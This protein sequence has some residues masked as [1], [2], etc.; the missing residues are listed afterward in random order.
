MSA[1]KLY[2][3]L[4]TYILLTIYTFQI[5]TIGNSAFQKIAPKTILNVDNADDGHYDPYVLLARE[6]CTQDK[7][8]A[9]KKSVYI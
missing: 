6:K 1:I 4:I 9:M 7:V 2:L 5:V 8:Y 3:L